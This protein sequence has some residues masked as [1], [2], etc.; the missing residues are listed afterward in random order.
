ML[1]KAATSWAEE[2]ITCRWR[3][4]KTTVVAAAVVIAVA[5]VVVV[6]VVVFV[7][8]LFV[9]VVVVFETRGGVQWPGTPM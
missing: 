1:T 8:V 4:P 7:F 3:Y 5:E 2:Q 9:F 6:I